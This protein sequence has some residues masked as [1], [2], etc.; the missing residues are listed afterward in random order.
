[1]IAA[2][3]PRKYTPRKPNNTTLASIQRM[4]DHIALNPGVSMVDLCAHFCAAASTLRH[5]LGLLRDSGHVE[6][7]EGARRFRARRQQVTT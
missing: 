6:K 7:R 3:K 2:S 5:S 4:Y 1:M